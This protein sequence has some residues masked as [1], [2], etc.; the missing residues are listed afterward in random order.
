MKKG[1]CL[2]ID[3]RKAVVVLVSGEGEVIQEITSN[4]ESSPTTQNGIT[5]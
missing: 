2:W 5:K 1:I 4:V 3:H